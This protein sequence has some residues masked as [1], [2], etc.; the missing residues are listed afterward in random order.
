M[1]PNSDETRLR[2]KIAMKHLLATKFD[3]NRAVDLYRTHDVRRK[4]FDFFQL[5]FFFLQNLRKSEN[6]DRI[7]IKNP[8]LIREI[9]SSKFFSLVSRCKEKKRKQSKCCL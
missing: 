5:C 6:L 8:H 2:W 1:Q 7:L 4:T 3:V 9:E